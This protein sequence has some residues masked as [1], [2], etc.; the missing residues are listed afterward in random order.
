MIR[1]FA[2]Y[3]PKQSLL[4]TL[5][6]VVVFALSA[7]EDPTP[8]NAPTAGNASTS[9]LDVVLARG[10]LICGVSGELS[11]FSFVDQT[12]KYSGLDVDICKAIAA[13]LFDNPDAV[14]YRNLNAKERFTAL[15]TG[16]IDVLSRN[17]TWTLSRDTSGKM[18]FAPVVFYDGQGVMVRKDSNIKSLDDLK[19][20]AVCAQNGT[21]TE[22]NLADQMRK[23]NSSYKPVTFE[24]VNATF[25]AYQSGRCAA[26]TADRSA[27]ISRRTSFPNPDDH[28]V[29]DVSISKE[30]LAPAVLNGDSKWFDTVKWIVYATME[31]EELGITSKN[32]PEQAK[33]SNATVK[34]FL[35][36]EGT[37]GKDMGLSN[38][39]AARVIKHVGNYGEIYDRNMGKDSKFNLPRGLNKLWNDGGLIYS[40]PFR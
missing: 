8:K 17:T 19:D 25:S 30:P 26:V 23:R 6:L 38:D 32:L 1:S 29:L 21:T 33:S 39:F 27:L 12:G 28:V 2:R 11:G 18:E 14:Q 31:A 22:L 10:K 7:C 5:G 9:R 16:E 36:L 35:G 15:Q 13:A 37:L 24:D 20:V 3:S 40:P 34:R 4:A